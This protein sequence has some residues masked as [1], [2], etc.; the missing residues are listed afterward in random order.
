MFLTHLN[1]RCCFLLI[2]AATRPFQS[3]SFDFDLRRVIFHVTSRFANQFRFSSATASAK[4]VCRS[5]GCTLCIPLPQ[6]L[7]IAPCQ[8]MHAV[9][10]SFH[11]PGDCHGLG[12][13]VHGLAN[14]QQMLTEAWYRKAL[15]SWYVLVLLILGRSCQLSDVE[16][17]TS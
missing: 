16:G 13:V 4:G 14:A 1:V 17:W 15:E 9:Q 7:S 10:H 3:I 12:V 2:F 6:V 11:E 5:W 8:A